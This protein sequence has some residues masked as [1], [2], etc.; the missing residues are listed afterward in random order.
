MLVFSAFPVVRASR[1]FSLG[2]PNELNWSF[3]Y[4]YFL[5]IIAFLYLPSELSIIFICCL[6]L[7]L[8]VHLKHTQPVLCDA[9]VFA[10]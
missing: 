5:I 8:T 2:L 10:Y 1:M 9:F 3:D 4:Y 7:L 6:G